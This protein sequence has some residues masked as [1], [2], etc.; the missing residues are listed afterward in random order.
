MRLIEEGGPNFTA[1]NAINDARQ[2][3]G[4]FERDEEE[5]EK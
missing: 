2:V 1:A 4:I 5:E 3:T